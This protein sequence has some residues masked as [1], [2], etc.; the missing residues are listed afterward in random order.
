MRPER[1]SPAVAPLLV[2]GLLAATGLSEA[3]VGFKE[4]VISP[5]FGNAQSVYAADLDGDGDIDALSASLA[6]DRIRWWESDGGSPPLFTERILSTVPSGRPREVFATDVDGDGDTDVLA[7]FDDDET[8]RWWE[9]DG[10]SPPAFTERTITSTVENA[11]SVFA[12]DVD[13]DGDTDVLSGSDFDDPVRWYE[14]DGASPPTFTERSITADGEANSV[15][16]ADLDGD[17]DT[18]VVAAQTDSFNF[19]QVLWYQNDGGS[20]PTFSMHVVVTD[21]TSESE[22]VF[23]TDVDGDGDTDVVSGSREKLAW[24]ENDG[25]STPVFTERIISSA[26][27][28]PFPEFRSVFATDVDGDGDTDVLSA[29]AGPPSGE[30]KVAWF[31]SDGGSPPAFTERVISRPDAPFSVF[32]TDVDG[33]GD[34]DV[35]S[36]AAGD[37]EIAWYEQVGLGASVTGTALRRVFCRNLTTGDAGRTVPDDSMSWSCADLGVTA[38]AGDRVVLSSLGSAEASSTVGGSVFGLSSSAPRQVTCQNL[39]TAQT[40]QFIA[41]DQTWDCEARGLIVAAGDRIQQT[42]RGEV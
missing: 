22:S 41:P 37:G 36:A 17:G 25:G 13:G 2:V 32:A 27:V 11:K 5:G 7:A 26:A 3:Q 14:N 8:I 16:A 6:D 21:V 19:R 1:L 38:V 23:A 29:S 35:L 33:D 10:G 30:D 9:N 15:H 42:V 4:H 24:Y 40:L 34:T 18:D 20:P 31:E 39:T 28:E 12:A